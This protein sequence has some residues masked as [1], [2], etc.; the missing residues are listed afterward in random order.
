MYTMKG[1]AITLP[2]LIT[3]RY[4]HACG[5]VSKIDGETVNYCFPLPTIHNLLNPTF[6]ILYSCTLWRVVSTV[7]VRP[8]PGSAWH[9]PRFWRRVG[10]IPGRERPVFLLLEYFP[11]ECLLQ[12][13]TLWRQVRNCDALQWTMLPM[14]K[15]T[16][17]NTKWF[18]NTLTEIIYICINRNL[19]SICI[20]WK[21]IFYWFSK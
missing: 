8:E 14:N 13:D 11:G 15:C 6:Y 9:L 7:T 21:S 16:Y 2:S 10:D 18:G 1:Q 12:M 4:G 3:G 20:D 5:K 17:P 19:C